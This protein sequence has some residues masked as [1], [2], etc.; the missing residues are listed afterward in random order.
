MRPRFSALV[1]VLLLVVGGMALTACDPVV[2]ITVTTTADG[3]DADPGDGVCEAT[4]G[5]GDCTLRAAIDEGSAAWAAN[6]TVPAGTYALSVIDADGARDL[7]VSGSISI[8]WETSLAVVVQVGGGVGQVAVDVQPGARFTASGL[9]LVEGRLQVAGNAVL[10]RASLTVDP[11]TI[12][13]S[14]GSRLAVLPGGSVVLGNSE[15]FAYGSAAVENAG[16]ASLVYTTISTLNG[17]PGIST[18]GSGATTLQAFQYLPYGA[19]RG[20]FAQAHHPGCSG[21]LP[22]SN[23]G[24]WVPNDSCHL[25]GEADVQTATVLGTGTGMYYAATW[26]DQIPVG[27]AGCGTSS[28]VDAA[29]NPR[30]S[31]SN[32]DGVAQ[33]EPGNRESS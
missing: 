16:A 2:P 27:V 4:P 13:S 19:F 33:C 26:L 20:V 23:G 8:N 12:L 6:L 31:D 29:G 22:Q 25:T 28:T 24:N 30:P 5:V 14:G 17:G 7:D 18:T 10:D 9:Q 1:T 15:V 21:N 3:S 32:G 11:G